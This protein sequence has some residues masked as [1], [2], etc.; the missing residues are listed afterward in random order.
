[1]TTRAAIAL[2]LALVLAWAGSLWGTWRIAHQ[3][4]RDAVV[5]QQSLDDKVAERVAKLAAQA[6][7]AAVARIKVQQ[8][9]I[10][11]EVQ[12]EVREIPVYRDCRH[13]DGQLQ[14]LNALAGHGPAAAAAGV[15][16][17]PVAA[18]RA[19]DAGHLRRDDRSPGADADPL[20][21]VPRRDGA[22]S[23]PAVVR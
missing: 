13:P 16:Q 21:A 22:G 9:T 12:R 8:Q 7:G 20:R 18:D 14:R 11:S 6:A 17:L 23:A 2:T 5:A 1:M 3:A 4:G 10:L 15:G 19:A